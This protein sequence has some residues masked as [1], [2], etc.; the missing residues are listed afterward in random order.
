M[1]GWTAAVWLATA[2]P[3]S[4]R[5]GCSLPLLSWPNARL[6]GRKPQDV[7]DPAQGVDQPRFLRVHLATQ[8]GHVRLND[9]RVTTEVVVPYVI[10]DLHLGQH[11]VRIA[12]EVPEQLELGGGE[13][14]LLPGPPHLVAFL[15]KF[16]V[17]ER[18]PGRRLDPVPPGT[19]EH[20][21]DPGDYL[22]T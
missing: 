21:T 6:G 16:E 3:P 8:H 1:C 22:F 20:G 7:P 5:L 17:G 11:P 15:V 19:A 4:D 12:H 9:A 2:G 13:L 18:K 14:N 10:E